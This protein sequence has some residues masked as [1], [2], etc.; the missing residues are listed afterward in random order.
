MVTSIVQGKGK[1]AQKIIIIMS[2]CHKSGNCDGVHYV[3]RDTDVSR[4]NKKKTFYRLD[5]LCS[6]RST[7]L[8]DGLT[9]VFRK[10]LHHLQ[11]QKLCRSSS[12]PRLG[13]VS[14][15]AC[16]CWWCWVE[17]QVRQQGLHPHRGLLG[18]RGLRLGQHL[19]QTWGRKM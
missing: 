19:G 18:R 1:K 8:P 14:A 6:R 11:R 4:E 17:L 5:C 13:P 15:V 12:P 3:L 7:A 2:S 9:V 16:G 10:L